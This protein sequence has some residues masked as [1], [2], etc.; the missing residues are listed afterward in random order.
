M[1]R[2]QVLKETVPPLAARIEQL[3]AEPLPASI[4]FLL[5]AAAAECPAALAWNFFELGATIDYATLQKTVNRLAC[6]MYEAG[7]RKGRHVGVMLPNIP[8][9]PLTWLALARLGAVMVP[10]NIAYTP[11]ELTFIIENGDVEW[12]VIHDGCLPALDALNPLPGLL[13]ADRIHTVGSERDSAH[14][15]EAL[16]DNDGDAFRPP[17]EVELDDPMNIQ[18]TSGTTGFPKGCVLS[19]RYWLI[20]SKSNAFRDGRKYAR[21]LA[22]TP[23][24]YMDPQWLLL[25]TFFQRGTL[26]VANRQ[27]PSRFMGWVREHRINFCLLPYLVHKQPE[28][29]DEKDHALVRVNVY[30]IPKD[31]HAALE[32]RFDLIA[33]EAFGMTE[34]GTCLFMPIEATDMTGSGSCGKPGPF[35]QA[36]IVDESGQAVQAGQVGELQVRGPGMLQGYY[37]NPQAT[38]AAFDGDWFRTGDLFRQDERGYFYIVGRVKDMIRRAGENIAAREVE[39]VI[40][41]LP[42]VA[43]AAAVPVPDEV[44]GEEVKV[45]VALREGYGPEDLPVSALLEH[46]AAKLAR[47]KIPRY[48]AYHG[49]LPKTPSGKIAKKQ[50][51]QGVADLKAGSYD[52][53]QEKWL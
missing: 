36:R 2:E 12:L 15:W 44:R 41:A 6:G 24:F 53:I 11:R 39:A 22:P 45:Y 1:S 21:I 25:M 7:I 8:A 38:A 29:P 19:H 47:F 9:F 16:L 51:T 26:F 10:I 40:T 13:R 23:F 20:T 14:H 5:D 33:R 3:E 35:R 52:R 31:L 37:K 18:Y 30:G 50:L 42:Q 46:C 28:A 43:E 49:T 27:S 4:G 32:E 34:C 17:Y 48:I